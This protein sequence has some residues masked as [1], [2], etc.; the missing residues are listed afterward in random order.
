[1]SNL[2]RQVQETENTPLDILRIETAL[3]RYPIHRLANKGTISID[4]RKKD[5]K[6]ATSLLWEVTYNSKYG[7]P[8]PLAYK[9]DTWVINRRIDE[10]GRPIP[11][12]LRLGSL[13][14]L[15]MELD[16]GRNTTAVRKALLQNVGAIINAKI[17]YKAVDKNERMLEA[18]FSRYSAVFTGEKLP[19][20]RQADA[21]YLVLNDIYAEVLNSAI[22]RPLDYDYLRNLSP[23]AQR[24]YEIVSYKMFPAIQHNQRARL[25][26]SEFCLYSTMTRYFEYDRVKKQ[27]HK[28]HLPHLQAGYIEKVKLEPTVDEAGQPDWNMFYIPGKI[29]CQ[30]QLVFD[31]RIQPP[32]RVRTKPPAPTLPKPKKAP[33]CDLQL[34]LLKDQKETAASDPRLSNLVQKF[35]QLRYGRHQSPT[36]RELIEAQQYLKEGDRWANYLIEFAAKQGSAKNGFPNDFG[37]IKKLIAQARIP[38]EDKRKEQ[39]AGHLKQARQSHEN[40]HRSAYH[41]FLRELLGG[42]LETSLP[43]AYRAFKEQEDRTYRFYLRR[44]E[45][46]DAG[47]RVKTEVANFYTEEVRIQRLLKFREDNPHCG[48]LDFWQWDTKLNPTPFNADPT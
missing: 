16:L 13:H 47:E 39:E 27:M 9:L 4:I 20:G 42:K 43:E 1:M 2:Q 37:G 45:K 11:K 26:Y 8:G 6:G 24:F 7:Q 25:P 44:S 12:V 38:F 33:S 5:E 19:D 36:E 32:A 21:V 35:Y 10:S 46:P 15:A 3:S 23:G 34:P 28:I 30:Q 29:A 14:D 41:A 48:I 40:A 22:R 31:F 18:A 17:A